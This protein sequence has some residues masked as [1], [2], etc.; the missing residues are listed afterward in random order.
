MLPLIN[1]GGFTIYTY[2]LMVGIALSI[3]YL[4]AE[5]LNNKETPPITSFKKFFLGLIFSSYLSAKIL[6]Y[7]T[8]NQNHT[9][10]EVFLSSGGLV[11]YGGVIGGLIYLYWY[12]K[13]YHLSFEKFNFLVPAICF[14]H[15]FGRLGCFFAGCCYGDFCELPW[16]IAQRHPV[17]IYE[18]ALVL[19]LGIFFYIEKNK[20]FKLYLVLYGVIRFVL[21]FFRGDYERGSVGFF[22]TSQIIALMLIGLSVFFIIKERA[23][24]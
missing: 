17:Q 14:S 22:S 8:S 6:F 3:F 1:I 5:F 10:L 21:E 15:A 23:R 18:A 24:S 20:S 9:L 11:F 13:K 19:C 16:A 4:V 12:G 2:P 7:F